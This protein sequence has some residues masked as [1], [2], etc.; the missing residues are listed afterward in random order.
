MLSSILKDV[1]QSHAKA[2]ANREAI[3]RNNYA[4]QVDVARTVKVS[5]CKW[6]K[7]FKKVT[8]YKDKTVWTKETRFNDAQYNSDLEAARQKEEAAKVELQEVQAQAEAD[9]QA[10]IASARSQQSAANSSYYN[11]NSQS[12]S[13]MSAKSAA[14]SKQSQLS[15]Q[16]I[17]LKTEILTK[18]SIVSSQ[19]AGLEEKKSALNLLL[20]E[21]TDRERAELLLNLYSITS[22]KA[23][24]VLGQILRLGFD[25]EHAAVRA[26]NDGK[27]E[28]F[29]YLL[30]HY[31]VNCDRWTVDGESLLSYGARC[32][33]GEIVEEMVVSTRN[34]ECT[35]I[36]CLGR[37]DRELLQKLIALKPELLHQNFDVKGETL[38][39]IAIGT[40]ARQSVEYL[41]S[42][43]D[44]DSEFRMLDL[45][46]KTAGYSAWQKA[47]DSG[48]QE[49]ILQMQGLVNI[50][51]EFQDLIWH[52]YQDGCQKIAMRMV[53]LDASL[54]SGFNLFYA[55]E[56]SNIKVAKILASEENCEEAAMIAISQHNIKVVEQLCG[57]LEQGDLQERLE[58]WLNM[59]EQQ[60]A[61]EFQDAQ[62]DE[63]AVEDIYA[64]FD[65]WEQQYDSDAASII[66]EDEQFIHHLD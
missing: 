58:D 47:I 7:W 35:I 29:A 2:K 11:A 55:L 31:A 12:S 41:L 54:A 49:I 21:K 43:D 33:P 5:F 28:L 10:Q 30:N 4:Y 24:E 18:S 52:K 48:Y 50:E 46:S 6:N 27:F 8:Y 9:Y 36:S 3:N 40:G 20:T 17:R 60:A 32:A 16:K 37:D 51:A 1:L 42:L 62:Y 53:E 34:M 66:G 13:A 59:T 44:A 14:T 26:L 56:Q 25:L 57:L 39:Q 22:S 38:L 45:R 65:N 61:E 63:L 15:S 64:E 19:E 23:Q